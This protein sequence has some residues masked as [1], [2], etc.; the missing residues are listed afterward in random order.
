[1]SHTYQL[2]YSSELN[3]TKDTSSQNFEISRI[4]IHSKR[5][6]S[7]N[8][9][10][11]V[12]YCANGLFFQVLEGEREAVKNLFEKI[13]QDDRHFN[14]RVL[15]EGEVQHAQF[16]QWSMHL[17]S[18][19][20]NIRRML[21]DYKIKAFVPHQFGRQMLEQFTL[22]LSQD[23]QYDKPMFQANE[24]PKSGLFSGFKKRR[25]TSKAA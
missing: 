5:Y 23:G 19:T 21:N 8:N 15:A 9:I 14:V 10:H 6:N 24:L 18:E 17:V 2:I 20:Q 12:L 4:L 11:G 7:Q 16:S 1:M 3:Q 25:S 13:K 22:V